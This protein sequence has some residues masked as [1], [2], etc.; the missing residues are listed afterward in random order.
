VAVDTLWSR[1]VGGGYSEIAIAD[2][3]AFTLELRGADDYL[4]A[5][6]AATGREAWSLRL[7]PTYQGHGGSDTG[8]IGTPAVDGNDVFAVGPHGVLVAADAATGHEKW[9]HDLTRDFGA[10]PP[11]WGFAASPLVEGAMVIVPTGGEKSRGL[12]AFD[13]ARGTLVWNVALEQRPAYTSAVVAELGGVRQILA[14]SPDRLFAVTPADGR[15]LW[16]TALAGPGVDLGNSPI[17]IDGDRVLVLF[18]EEARLLRVGRAS[19]K[20]WSVNELWR[21]PRLRGAFGPVVFR[22]GFFYGFAGEFLT[23]VNADTTKVAWRERFGEGR[24]IA[25]GDNLVILGETTGELTVAAMSPTRFVPSFRARV[26][27]PELRSMTGPSFSD[28]RVYVRNLKQ[29][30]ALQ[31]R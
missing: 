5:L 21:T 7:G 13:R 30:A 24:L 31:P 23:C 16:S 2:G 8:P 18:W 29:I 10:T 11:T 26:L 14:A 6:D 20:T 4:V 3:R 27:E 28:G 17:V 25:V 22:D 12:L 15:L 19:D 9:R 1:P